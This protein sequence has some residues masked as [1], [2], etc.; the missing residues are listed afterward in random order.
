MQH[1]S[2]A[3][4]PPTHFWGPANV[5][6][7]LSGFVLLLC[8]ANSWSRDLNLQFAVRC[9]DVLTAKDSADSVGRRVVDDERR[10]GD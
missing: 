7:G 6:F 5:T 10:A 8:M 2:C 1:N 4:P 9:I 3:E